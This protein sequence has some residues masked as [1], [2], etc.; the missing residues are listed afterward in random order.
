MKTTDI[1][2]TEIFFD[3]NRDGLG[4]RKTRIKTTRVEPEYIGIWKNF[5]Q[6]QTFVTLTDDVMFVNVIA[7][8]M[9]L[10][11][12]LRSF[13]MERVTIRSHY[14]SDQLLLTIRPNYTKLPQNLLSLLG[15]VESVR[16]LTIDIESY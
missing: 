3:P 15:D 8:L 7:F 9:T 6:Q 2:N 4:E 14:P 13:T 11:R 5:Y 16:S 12:N 1:N 10:S